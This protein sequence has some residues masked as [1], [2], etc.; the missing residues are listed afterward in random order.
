[1]ST[2]ISQ[3]TSATDV[4][5]NDFI[6]IVDVEDGVMAPSGTNKKA[7]AILL[8]NQLVPLIDSGSIAGSKI[9]DGGIT[10]SKIATGTIVN[11]DI[12]ASAAIAG[13]KISP[14]FGSQNIVTTGTISANVESVI[15]GSSSGDALRIT[16]TGT[17]NALVI[18]DS[19][20]PDATP[21]VVDANGRIISG[22]TSQIAFN[23]TSLPQV[24]VVGTSIA[25]SA[26]ASVSFN[27]NTESPSSLLL[28]K[29]R[30]TQS[31]PI[32][33]SD[34]DDIGVIQFEAHDGV[35]L[36][37][38][39]RILA[40]VDGNPGAGSMPG[41]LLFSTTPTGSTNP[42]EALRITSGQ[43]I[44]IAKT[45]VT[46]PV[47]SDGNVFSGTYIPTLT[48]VTNLDTTTAFECN[49]IRVGN[50]ITVSGVFNANP[51][52]TGD[53]EFLMSLPINS[54]FSAK[55]QLGGVAQ[56]H[57]FDND[58]TVSIIADIT[59]DKAQF[60]WVT[61]RTTITGY[62]FTFTYRVI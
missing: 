39:A 36:K 2:K 49:Y 43:G 34:G 57:N 35:N 25:T 1:M 22:S 26:I 30:G 60:C 59:N 29:G 24:E 45:S 48:N 27:G 42:V 18:E 55:T 62:S 15:S 9:A 6:Q 38:A 5:A 41:M 16:Q 14:D 4:T 11:T 19:T 8:A 61:G 46:N 28:G 50:V 13:T 7:T 32:I 3:L 56:S 44:Q 51:T 12:S 33:V 21:F 53:T 37:P 54:A 52:A 17:G 47:A 20:S 10:S 58:G 23:Y 40:E 31:S